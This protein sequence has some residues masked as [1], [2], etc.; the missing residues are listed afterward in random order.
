[1]ELVGIVSLHKSS[2]QSQSQARKTQST[3]SHCSKQKQRNI[4]RTEFKQSFNELFSVWDLKFSRRWVSKL[5]FSGMWRRV[6]WQIGTNILGQPVAFTVCKFGGLI[7][8]RNIDTYL[9]EYTAS[10]SFSTVYLFQKVKERN[11]PSLFHAAQFLGQNICSTRF[12]FRHL[13]QLTVHRE[14]SHYTH[15]RETRASAHVSTEIY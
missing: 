3:S 10:F 15:Q 8:L 7:P 1:M 11:V 4:I 14:H 13:N 9:R 6:I 12:V 5:K 2:P